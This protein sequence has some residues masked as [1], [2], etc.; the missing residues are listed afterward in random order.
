MTKKVLL[1][2]EDD[3]NDALL[4]ERALRRASSPFRL[5]RVADGEQVV[6]YIAGADPYADRIAH[7]PPDLLLLDLKMPRMD[8]FEVLRWR[9]AQD[10]HRLPVIVFSSSTLERDIHQA[11]A[12]GAASYAVKPLRSEQLDSFA[13]ALVAW[14]AAVHISAP[15]RPSV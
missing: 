14:W 13:Q 5:V 2:A 8:G 3:D 1:V 12:L 4:L 6:S 10:L 11:S 15:P 7:P 9:K